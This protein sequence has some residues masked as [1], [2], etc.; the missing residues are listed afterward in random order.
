MT[1]LST[2]LMLLMLD[3]KPEVLRG[4]YAADPRQRRGRS[5]HFALC[6]SFPP[7]SP[8]NSTHLISTAA[9]NTPGENQTQKFWPRILPKSSFRPH[10]YFLWLGC[11]GTSHSATQ[12]QLSL[13]STEAV[14]Q[15]SSLE[16]LL[17]SKLPVKICGGSELFCPPSPGQSSFHRSDQ[18]RQC[19]KT[20]QQ[21]QLSTAQPLCPQLQ[22][23]IL[24]F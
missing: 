20:T 5:A 18:R 14:T 17:H 23:S 9:V 12:Y 11:T 4:L 3:V 24:P 8:P 7:S 22:D 10:V 2:A 21:Q 1:E 16:P 6:N 15:E 19:V 13:H